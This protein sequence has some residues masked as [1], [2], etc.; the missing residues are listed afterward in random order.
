MR[1]SAGLLLNGNISSPKFANWF[2]GLAEALIPEILPNRCGAKEPTR[3]LGR[4]GLHEVLNTT[5]GKQFMWSNDLSGLNGI[6]SVAPQPPA[7][8]HSTMFIYGDALQFD[9]LKLVTLYKAIAERY[10]VDYGYI[11]AVSDQEEEYLFQEDYP[12]Y[13]NYNS[14]VVTASLRK[15]LPDLPWMA[16]FGS[17]YIE[18]LGAETIL[19]TPAFRVET[20]NE[21][22]IALQL[23]ESISDLYDYYERFFRI[24]KAARDLFGAEYFL[25]MSKGARAPAFS[26]LS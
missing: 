26:S 21:K 3:K 25:S 5:W 12:S 13:E 11:H 9:A 7:K 18:L 17:P 14:G 6:W 4:L 15:G 24:R 8:R 10:N 19:S 16:I 1:I 22:L 23:T 20:W 2:F